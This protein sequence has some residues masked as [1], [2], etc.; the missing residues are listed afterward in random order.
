VN[1]DVRRSAG[2]GTR[3]WE[4]L[5]VACIYESVSQ[6][7]MRRWVNSY[8]VSNDVPW[9]TDS[10]T[11]GDLDVPYH[12]TPATKQTRERGYKAGAELQENA[13]DQI[14]E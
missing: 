1:A 9:T 6:I 5:P 3:D 7:L 14:P 8:L 4:I 13:G 11:Y 2:I 10:K 12:S